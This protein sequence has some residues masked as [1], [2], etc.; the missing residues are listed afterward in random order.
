M[1]RD[2][3]YAT[4][5]RALDAE[6]LAVIGAWRAGGDP[7][8]GDAFDALALRL[9]AYQLQYN[10]AY[11]R[12]CARFGFTPS[13]LPESWEQIPPVPAAAFKDAALATFNPS[14]AALVFATSG[15]T[16]GRAGMHYFESAALYDAALLAGFDRFVL[17]DGARLQ[18]FLL[19]PDPSERTAS[20]L[21]YMMRAVARA[22]GAGDAGWYLRADELRFEAFV[23]DLRDAI[24]GGR[25]VCIAATAFALVHALEA[26][27]AAGLR[28][29]LPAGSRIMETG[30]FKG[31]TRA[32]ER[33][34]LYARLQN[35]FEVDA[36]A[37]VAEYGMTELTSQYYDDVLLRAGGGDV[38][39][40]AAPPWLR[41]RVVG[42]D[43]TTL[44]DG[45]VGALVHVDLANRASCLA[46]STE[47]LGV[48]FAEPSGTGLGTFVLL[49]RES[50]ASLRGCSLD[51]ETLSSG[52]GR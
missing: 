25:P 32:I 2:P 27:N 28:L 52:L 51:A 37:I 8:A 40:K 16:A 18:F 23:S 46:I 39:R 15:T 19:V 33:S 24:A 41:A 12:Y 36:A 30:G 43:G 29:P 17:P 48:R 5:S 4:A 22:R 50:G 3:D 20:S 7:L 45:T 34:D 42:P 10:R 13:S 26:M 1:H 9:F 21:G 49:G 14:E 35:A 11:A 31:R 47:D 6:I 38:R 44:P